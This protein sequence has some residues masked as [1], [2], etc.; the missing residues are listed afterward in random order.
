MS[1]TSVCVCVPP[2]SFYRS[3]RGD[4]DGGVWVQLS[5]GSA[6]HVAHEVPQREDLMLVN[7]LKRLS[8]NVAA[9]PAGWVVMFVRWRVN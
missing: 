1:V 9:R 7:G 4:G 6:G 2:P 5:P 3:R 8:V